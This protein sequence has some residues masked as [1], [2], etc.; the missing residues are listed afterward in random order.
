MNPTLEHMSRWLASLSKAI[1][2]DDDLAEAR[3]SIIAEAA[4]LG[5]SDQAT[6]A[7]E[8]YRKLAK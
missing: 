6:A 2:R 7:L 5:V 8:L 3:N 4:D 1:T